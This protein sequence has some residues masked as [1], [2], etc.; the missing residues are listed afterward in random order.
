MKLERLRLS[1]F[2]AFKEA[3]FEFAAGVN[4]L[5]GENAS[6]K[7][8]VLKLLYVLNEAVRRTSLTAESGNRLEQFTSLEHALS[9]LLMQ[10]F[11]PEELGRLVRR[12]VGNRTAEISAEWSS[13]LKIV[14][15]LTNFGKLSV[16]KTGPDPKLSTSVFV[17]LGKF[18][19]FFRDSSATGRLEFR[20]SIALTTTYAWLSMLVHS[21]ARAM[22]GV[23]SFLCRS[24]PRLEASLP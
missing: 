8:H 11:M 20:T 4:V 12:A 22:Q 14:A 23:V 2:T 10:T 16:E 13:G 3:T 19:P 6:G 21:A 1:K 15:T 7:S 18:F 9:T 24:K 17:P 5:I